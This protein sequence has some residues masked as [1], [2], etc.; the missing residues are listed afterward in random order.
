M[1]RIEAEFLAKEVK[2]EEQMWFQAK[3]RPKTRVYNLIPLY[4]ACV[5]I[6]FVFPESVFAVYIHIAVVISFVGWEVRNIHKRNDAIAFL[7]EMIRKRELS[8]KHPDIAETPP[9]PQDG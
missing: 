5:G 9:S 1:E 7:L 6:P 4:A 8:K 3:R 2:K